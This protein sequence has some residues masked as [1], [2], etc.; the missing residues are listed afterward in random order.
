[1]KYLLILIL[2]IGCAAKQ[3]R[4][5]ENSNLWDAQVESEEK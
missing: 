5:R 3:P 1:M 4:P 2:L